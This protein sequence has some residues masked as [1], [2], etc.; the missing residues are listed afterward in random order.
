L[1]NSSKNAGIEKI[2]WF[3]LPCAIGFLVIGVVVGAPLADLLGFSQVAF[4]LRFA[5]LFA[6]ACSF[7]LALYLGRHPRLHTVTE[8]KEGEAFLTWSGSERA[9]S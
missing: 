4:L 6:W 8:P 9:S 2:P 3:V 1:V 5:P 7:G